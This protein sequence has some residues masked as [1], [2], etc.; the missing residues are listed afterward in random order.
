MPKNVSTAVKPIRLNTINYLRVKAPNTSQQNSCAVVMSSMLS[1]WASSGQGS[2]ACT[3]LETQLKECMDT[4]T[5]QGPKSN[6]VNYHLMRMYPKV[7]GPKKKKGVI[8]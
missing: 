7:V 5:K 4:K 6:T 2:E 3:L 8:G 1:C